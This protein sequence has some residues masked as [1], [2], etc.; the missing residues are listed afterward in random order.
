M[1]I[2]G[3]KRI[4][5]YYKAT[6]SDN[7]HEDNI[8]D[9]EDTDEEIAVAVPVSKKAVPSKLPK[10]T[11]A[12]N[13]N[14]SDF[15]NNEESDN[16]SEVVE[17]ENENENEDEEE[18]EE[19]EEEED[20]EEEE[21]E[22]GKDANDPVHQSSP[23]HSGLSNMAETLLPNEEVYEDNEE[24]EEP[25]E[26]Y[27]QKFD[28]NIR[29]NYVDQFHPETHVHNYEEIAAMVNVVRNKDNIIVD[30]LHRTI[31]I[32]TKYERTR[33]LGQRAKQINSGSRP[34]VSVPE[35]IIDGYLIAG[36]ELAQKRVPFIIR[37]PLPGNAGCEYWRVS[38]LESIDM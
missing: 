15:E 19:E 7:E 37:R 9:E 34:Y 28:T 26:S 12:A 27:L 11:I 4:S 25:D 6:M 2:I 30:P 24:D 18:E 36:L 17:L 16:E 35:D 8:F 20:A 31:P 21:E 23:N 29:E 5:V 3:Y 32:L 10:V 14:D 38:D 22:E 13:D 33:I 1:N